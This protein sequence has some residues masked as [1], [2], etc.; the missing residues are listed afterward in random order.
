MTEARASH[1]AMRLP[2]GQVLVFGDG[3]TQSPSM[4]TYDPQADTWTPR[5]SERFDCR[6]L[7]ALADGRAIISHENSLLIYDPA[8][9]TWTP[10]SSYV[11]YS[12]T[13]TLLESGQVLIAGG[14]VEY[15]SH[16]GFFLY[17]PDQDLGTNAGQMLSER[18][19]HTATR[20]ADGRVL[21]AGGWRWEIDEEDGVELQQPLASTEIFDPVQK[22]FSAAAPMQH[23][24]KDHQAVRLA[25]GRVLVIGGLGN[26]GNPELYDPDT[27]TWSPVPSPG[28]ARFG[29]TVTLLPDSR[30]VMVGGRT[31][32]V[33]I[34]DPVANTWASLPPLSVSR[35]HHITTLLPDQRLLVAGG[36]SGSGYPDPAYAS[37]EIY[38]FDA[39]PAGAACDTANDCA[40]GTCLEGI[41][42]DRACDGTC[43]TCLAAAGATADGVCTPLTGTPCDDGDSCTQGDVCEQ[44]TCTSTPVVCEPD[45]TDPGGGTDPGDDTNPGDGTDPGTPPEDGASTGRGCQMGPATDSGHAAGWLLLLGAVLLT[46][47]HGRRIRRARD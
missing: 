38:D 21:L 5:T 19:S 42:C 46:H 47:R 3:D 34:Y 1:C 36:Q 16:D 6:R 30:V 22:T 45:G 41:C 23:P 27:D 15:Y 39:A 7:T 2:D 26:P 24:R 4:E 43:E 11:H 9:D 17:E 10:A 25:D 33:D 28:E 18:A 37:A 8:D 29:H 14:Y 44:G 31:D 20:L 12:H 13:A 32:A 35:T 40:S